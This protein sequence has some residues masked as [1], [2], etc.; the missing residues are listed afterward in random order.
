MLR[1]ISLKKYLQLL[2]P[3]GIAIVVL[4]LVFFIL[5]VTA[6]DGDQNDDIQISSK[7]A[8]SPDIAISN[9]GTY[10]AVAYYKQET[11]A[12]NVYVKSAT[13]AE[14]WLSSQFVGVG[15][16]PRLA[17]S[18]NTTVHVVWTNSD[19]K[20]IKYSK[21]TLSLLNRPACSGDTIHQSI[22]NLDTPDIV[23]DSDGNIHVAWANTDQ[24]RI[25]TSLSTNGGDSWSSPTNVSNG[26]NYDRRPALATSN[27]VHLA[28]LRG[29]NGSAAPTSVEYRR[30]DSNTSHN[31]TGA[32]DSF[33]IGSE[34]SGGYDEL[35]NPTMVATGTNVYLAWDN[36]KTGGDNFALMRAH[37]TN[38]GTSWKAPLHITSENPGSTSTSPDDKLSKQS[39][40][41]VQE[42]ALRPS[43]TIS[44]TTFAIVWQQRPSSTCGGGES[45][46]NATHEIHYAYTTTTWFTGTLA[47][48]TSQNS[49]DPDL[50]V[51][52]PDGTRHFVFMK[53]QDNVS[54]C[55]GGLAADY[56]IYYRGPFTKT[57]NDQGE[58][59]IYLPLIVKNS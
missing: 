1:L 14:G 49:V 48:V 54:T 3:L 5:P 46:G 12:G 38:N 26:G 45:G 21:C 40:V 2:F 24:G 44:G 19:N 28:F 53:D 18:D 30:S 29:P 34:I 7:G 8:G 56:A 42:E 13:A 20:S 25:E 35:V 4:F 55:E 27:P 33:A 50:A 15:S 52:P 58:P 36:H 9:D 57:D 11:G 59:G 37:S 6:L 23:V 16:N 17:F 39:S 41:P 31:W 22:E 43:M 47:N 10:V 51:A 32:T